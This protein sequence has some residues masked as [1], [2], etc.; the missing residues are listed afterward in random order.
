MPSRTKIIISVLV[1]IL[2]ICA[3]VGISPSFSNRAHV[4]STIAT[5]T[6]ATTQNYTTN[7]SDT[8]VT[9]HL[10]IKDITLEQDETSAVSANFIHATLMVASTSYS[11]SVPSGSTLAYGMRQL[12]AQSASLPQPFTYTKKEYPGMGEFVE[13][14]NGIPNDAHNFWLVYVNNSEAPTGISNIIIHPGD[15]VEWRYEKESHF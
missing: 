13:S 2:A 15:T 14:I 1:V 5:S 10:P 4:S 9:K 3:I 7:S 11:I 6:P 12:V 8:P